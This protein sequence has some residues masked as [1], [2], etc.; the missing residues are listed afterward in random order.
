MF[1][2]PLYS[3]SYCIQACILIDGM[4][5]LNKVIEDIFL[6]KQTDNNSN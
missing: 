3:S 1:Y 4:T 5:F 6:Y 2:F